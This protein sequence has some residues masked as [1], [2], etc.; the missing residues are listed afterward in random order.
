MNERK[1]SAQ[2][3]A[4]IPVKNIDA[5]IACADGDAALLYFHIVR[6]GEF[7]LTRACR[8]LKR[9]ESEILRAAETL[10]RL[11]LVSDEHALENDTL[12]QYTA[13]DITL[14][15]KTDAAFEGIVQEAQKALGKTLNS[16]DLNIL[17]GIYDHIGLPAEMIFLLINHCIDYTRARQGEGRV[18][19]MKSIETEAWFWAKNEITTFDA[20]EEHIRREKLRDEDEEKVKAVLQIRG[21]NLTASEKR[22]IS[23]WLDMGFAPDALAV[24]YD[25]TVLGTGKMVWKYM[26]KIVTSWHEKN[27]HTPAEIEE[28]DSRFTPKPSAAPAAAPA[29]DGRERI[30]NMRKLY[31]KMKG[32][33]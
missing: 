33:K 14:R 21:R 27:L 6:I 17:F 31:E 26:D 11:G 3:V 19:T 24:A 20:A 30:E 9:G 23:A 29:A 28:G 2:T 16:N 18:P 7:S 8:D 15:A 22:Y 4:E 32:A 1:S 12:P 25:R 5:I 10:R 13:A